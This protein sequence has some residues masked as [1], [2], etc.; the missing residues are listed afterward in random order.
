MS[1]SSGRP[2]AS[3]GGYLHKLKQSHKVL[4][5]QWNR[6]WFSIEGRALRWYWSEPSGAEQCRGVI[7]LASI[8]LQQ[9]AGS[10]DPT[11]T[12][13]SPSRNLMLRAADLSERD[14]WIRKLRMYADFARGGDGTGF[15]PVLDTSPTPPSPASKKGGR[16]EDRMQRALEELVVLERNE[17]QRRSV[18]GF[19]LPSSITPNTSSVGRDRVGAGGGVARRKPPAPNPASNPYQTSVNIALGARAQ[20]NS[21][22][23]QQGVGR[24]IRVGGGLIYTGS[25]GPPTDVADVGGVL[26]TTNTLNEGIPSSTMS[27]LSSLSKSA[28]STGIGRGSHKFYGREDGGDAGGEDRYNAVGKSGN[29]SKSSRISQLDP[30]AR[31]S[32][33]GRCAATAEQLF[34]SISEI[35]IGREVLNAG[36]V[37]GGNVKDAKYA[38]LE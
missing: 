2:L 32:H 4:L 25:C 14:K 6:R 21:S 37:T 10:P 7:D 19:E 36:V 23:Q 31:S 22:Q 33:G 27:S 29:D 13:T 1:S 15:M 26:G 8:G 12:I 9:P 11:F 24:G 18:F 3:H 16:L 34:D 38:W 35:D 28:A 30:T 17:Q 20:S 5:P